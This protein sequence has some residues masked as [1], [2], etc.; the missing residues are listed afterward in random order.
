MEGI[1]GSTSN[2]PPAQSEANF[3]PGH[4][5]AVAFSNHVLARIEISPLCRLLQCCAFYIMRKFFVMSNLNFSSCNLSQLLLA[6][7]SATTK[8]L[9]LGQ[10]E[11]FLPFIVGQMF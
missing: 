1:S 8:K 10:T 4:T 9:P 3:N 2:A 6:K 5:P 11:H 7:S